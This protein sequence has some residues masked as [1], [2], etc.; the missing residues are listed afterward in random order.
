MSYFCSYHKEE[1]N[2]VCEKCINEGKPSASPQ[3][4]SDLV[5]KKVKDENLE[6]AYCACCEE[7]G[8]CNWQDFVEH[9]FNIQG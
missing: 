5:S 1:T 4:V 7:Y 3:Y 2:G 9:Q 8:A 6:K